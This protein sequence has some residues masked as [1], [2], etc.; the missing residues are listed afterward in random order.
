MLLALEVS[1]FCNF[2]FSWGNGDEIRPYKAKQDV[3]VATP[4]FRKIPSIISV[5]LEQKQMHPLV[6]V[7]GT[8]SYCVSHHT[9]QTFIAEQA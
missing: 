2:L 1:R 3:M 6:P 4:C 7:F 5:E 8:Y 9:Q